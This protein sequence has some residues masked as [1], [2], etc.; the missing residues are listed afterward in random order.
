M[1]MKC[2]NMITIAHWNNGKS[3]IMGSTEFVKKSPSINGYY[4]DEVCNGKPKISVWVQDEAPFYTSGLRVE[5]RCSNCGIEIN[6]SAL[7]DE[8][9]LQEWINNLI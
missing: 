9:N 6:D 1:K 2:K 4:T 8:D 7:P 3:Q 5:W